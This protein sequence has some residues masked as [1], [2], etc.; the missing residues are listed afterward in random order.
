MLRSLRPRSAFTLIELLV[1]IG[2]IAILTGLLL[3]AVQ[4]VRESARRS[5]CS[6]H[7]RQIGLAVAS[8]HVTYRKL[9]VGCLEWRSGNN[10][11]QRQ[12][13]WSAQILPQLE[14]VPLAQQLDLTKA[15]DAPAN[16]AAAAVTV[17]IFLCPSSPERG[18]DS[19]R[20]RIDYG[21]IYGERISGPNHPP[22]GTM[23]IDRAI[24]FREINDG[25]SQTLVVGEDA[26]WSD[27]EWVNGR[28]I[29]DQAFAINAAPAFENDLRS[30]HP[31]GVNVLFCDGHVQF[32]SD[33]FNLDALAA[34]CTRAGSEIVNPMDK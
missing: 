27:G 23:L 32:L 16:R 2:I 18:R 33:E 5:G 19:D 4:Q 14:Q 10:P 7:L 17:P 15:F 1:V 25:L 31:G 34:I 26:G 12:L 13:A 6:S 3:P 29:F 11:E 21:G 30:D 20:G 28:N 8:Y 9:P 22:K 24:R